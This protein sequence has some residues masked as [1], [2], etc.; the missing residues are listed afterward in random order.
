MSEATSGAAGT[1]GEVLERLSDEELTGEVSKL[2]AQLAAGEA[3]MVELAAE[4]DR[5]GLW[6]GK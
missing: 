6:G 2:A 3:R 5:R 1:T 4:A